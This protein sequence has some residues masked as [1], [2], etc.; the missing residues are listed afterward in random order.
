M[1]VDLAFRRWRAK[2]RAYY[3]PLMAHA[4]ATL[5]TGFVDE[6]SPDLAEQIEA[7][8][9]IG[10]DGIDVRWI[11]KTNVLDLS[12]DQISEIRSRCEDKGLVISSIGS[13]VNKLDLT[14]AHRVQE[15]ERLKKAM[16][17]AS[18]FG[19]TRIRVFSPRTDG[20]C[21]EEDW[22]AVRDW[23]AEQAA[24]AEGTDFVLVHENDAD[25]YGAF[26]EGS[27]RILEEL[28]GPNFKAVFDPA[29]SACMGIKTIPDWFPWIIPHL[30]SL[31][32]KDGIN[33]TRKFVPAGEG[34]AQIPE[35]LKLLVEADWSGPMALEPH[36]SESGA[37]SGF[38]GE[39][40]FA[41]AKEKLEA[42][43]G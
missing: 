28:S 7:A 29:N 37:F 14:E 35:M 20:G 23:M 40:L 16:E 27:R 30:D 38:T 9:R 41:V 11:G 39:K 2:L 3:N 4:P 5:V 43:L 15:L 26:P 19:V 8:A 24:L 42:L 36:L 18:A 22:P 1:N 13:P 32:I 10:L 12:A 34:E 21:R 6:I 33:G 17:Q 31:H 25:M